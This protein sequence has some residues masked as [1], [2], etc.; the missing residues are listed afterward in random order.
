MKSTG[1][2]YGVYEHHSGSLHT[3]IRF[4]PRVVT[5]AIDTGSYS[6]RI[7]PVD[8]RDVSTDDTLGTFEYKV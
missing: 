8:Q 1:G 7:E 3:K 2:E 6:P 5:S 4:V